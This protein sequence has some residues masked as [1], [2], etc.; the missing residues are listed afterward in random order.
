MKKLKDLIKWINDTYLKDV[1]NVVLG[2]N[3]AIQGQNIFVKG[4]NQNVEGQ[5]NYVFNPN[6]ANKK[7]S[8]DNIVRIS[9]FDIDLDKIETIRW[10]PYGA[11]KLL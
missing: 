8:G 11:I 5:S 3:N 9:K 1:N 2:S 7:I 6:Y 4:E 10:N